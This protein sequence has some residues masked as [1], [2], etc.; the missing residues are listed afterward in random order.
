MNSCIILSTYPVGQIEV[1]T[2]PVCSVGIPSYKIL[3]D[4][5]IVT[6]D[7]GVVVTDVINE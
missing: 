1:S 3:M 7:N 5:F 4:D 2:S 6:V